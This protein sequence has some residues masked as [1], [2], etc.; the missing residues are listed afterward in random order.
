MLDFTEVVPA[1]EFDELVAVSLDLRR[2]NPPDKDMVRRKTL[3]QFNHLLHTAAKEGSPSFS[4]EVACFE[5]E[6]P[7][8][9]EAMDDLVGMLN[10]RA[11]N[12]QAR[13]TLATLEIG[14]LDKD[15]WGDLPNRLLR[16]AVATGLSGNNI[17]TPVIIFC[18]YYLIKASVL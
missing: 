1:E 2:N 9:K 16:L 4:Y 18:F 3:N 5:H 6:L 12:Y 14:Q 13:L 8:Y 15:R 7:V 10:S 17:Y 11:K